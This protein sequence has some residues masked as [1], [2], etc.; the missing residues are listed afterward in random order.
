M[1]SATTWPDPAVA[2]VCARQPVTPV[3]QLPL[4][5][6]P[7]AGGPR[8]PITPFP[9]TGPSLP[10][11]E[12][13]ATPVHAMLLPEQSSVAFAIVQLDAP[14]T[15]G[16]P[17]FAHD[18]GA[19]GAGTAGWSC[20]G[21]VPCGASP[22]VP[23]LTVALAVERSATS[24]AITFASEADEAPELVTAW[25]TPPV[26]PSQEPSLCDPRAVGDTSGSVAVAALDTE[27]VQAIS[28]AQ[29]MAAPAAEAADGPAGSRAAFTCCG[30][31]ARASA[32]PGPLEAVEIDCTSQPPVAPVHDAVPS[33][34]R[35]TAP[36]HA[37]VLVRTDPVQG[38][39]GAHTRDALAVAVDDGPL[40]G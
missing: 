21:W 23:E 18:P 9:V 15:V 38:V 12:L 3:A 6:E 17:E 32:A 34:V 27:P 37:T 33:E 22:V 2:L 7:P 20:C 1:M 8:A 40:V 29:V 14:G 28:P 30:P 4:V 25:H 16:A 39:P 5:V 26:T 11:A 19:A 24:G 31:P 35:V 36:S 10:A 13:R